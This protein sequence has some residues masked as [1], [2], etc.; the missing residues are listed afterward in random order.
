MTL[1]DFLKRLFRIYD[2][3]EHPNHQVRRAF[4]KET[5]DQELLKRIA[6]RDPF[7]ERL[8]MDWV[9]D[10]YSVRVAAIEKLEDRELLAKLA[11]KGNHYSKVAAQ[12]RLAHLSG[13][14]YDPFKDEDKDY[15]DK[16]T[17]MDP[18]QSPFDFK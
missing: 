8:N 9:I 18:H 11:C 15:E 4:V 14:V 6:L 16:R 13:E 2:P 17:D 3:W 7:H 1:S 5:E 10:C 12:K